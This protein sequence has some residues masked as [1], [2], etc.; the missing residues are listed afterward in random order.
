MCTGRYTGR[1]KTNEA[2]QELHLSL[3]PPSRTEQYPLQ[4]LAPEAQLTQHWNRINRSFK[5]P[6]VPWCHSIGATS[7]RPPG[8]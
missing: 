3:G 5:A 6:E 7:P 2:L 8:M 4:P 1:Y